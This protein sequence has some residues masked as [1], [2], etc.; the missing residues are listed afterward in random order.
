MC[1]N[2]LLYL[3]RPQEGI[4]SPGTVAA[5]GCEL[6]RGCWELNLRPRQEQPVF[7]TAEPFPAPYEHY[8]YYVF[9]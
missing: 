9:K 8:F 6:S 2:L 1:A 4:G 5:G 3:R 7:S